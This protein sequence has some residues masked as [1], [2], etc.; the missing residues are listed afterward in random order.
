[1]QM[2]AITDKYGL[3]EACIMSL[4]AGVD[5]LI[6][7]NNLSYDP[8]IFAGIH[9]AIIEAIDKGTLSEDTI[10]S[11]WRRVQNYKSLIK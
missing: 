8:N 11:A 5:M 9:K 2:K 6:I 1:M 4:A 10:K 3:V 7:G